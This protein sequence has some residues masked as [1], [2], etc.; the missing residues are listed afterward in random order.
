T[1][2]AAVAGLGK[3]GATGAPDLVDAL[4]HP[5]VEVRRLSAQLLGPL[6]VSDRLVVV[7]LA[8]AAKDKDLQVATLALASLQRPGPLGKEAGPKLLALID[9]GSGDIRWMAL[10]TLGIVRPEAKEVIPFFEKFAKRTDLDARVLSEMLNVLQN[11]G[12]D[13]LPLMVP[14]L[15]NADKNV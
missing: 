9:E 3:M 7:G 13:V 4:G 1:Q 12:P 10:H 2:L 5:S 11:Y 14:F 6:R 15:D 8:H